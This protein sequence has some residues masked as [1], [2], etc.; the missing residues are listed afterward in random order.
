MSSNLLQTFNREREREDPNFFSFLTNLC[1]NV[2]LIEQ[3]H[4]IEYNQ[5]STEVR[6]VTLFDRKVYCYINLQKKI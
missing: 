6:R 1:V 2:L 5:L 4:K 3:K